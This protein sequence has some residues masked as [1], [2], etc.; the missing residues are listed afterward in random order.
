VF[1][2]DIKGFFRKPWDIRLIDRNI[3]EL[4]DADL[5]WAKLLM[6]DGTRICAASR[7]APAATMCC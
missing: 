5:H 3:E 2:L 4:G 7:P 1:D 6:S